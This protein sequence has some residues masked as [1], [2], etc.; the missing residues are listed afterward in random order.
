MI[1]RNPF[2]NFDLQPAIVDKQLVRRMLVLAQKTSAGTATANSIYTNINQTTDIDGLFG[3]GSHIAT[4]CHAI[5]GIMNWVGT[6]IPFDVIPIDDSGTGDEATSDLVVGGTNASESKTIK[7]TIGT[8]EGVNNAIIPHNTYSIAITSTED[9]TAVADKIRAAIAADADALVVGSG[10]AGTVT[11]TAKNK[12]T[13]GNNILIEVDGSVGG[14]TFTLNAFAGGANDPSVTTAL[15]NIENEEYDIICPYPF[16]SDVK[17]HLEVKFNAT[18]KVLA[19]ESFS[20]TTDT[21]SNFVIAGTGIHV[22]N[23]SK[24]SVILSNKIKSTTTKKGGALGVFDLTAIADFATKRALR[25]I[26][27]AVISKF[28]QPG[29]TRGRIGNSAIPYFNM[30]F[31][32]F[33]I[34]EPGENFSDDEIE[35]IENLGGSTWDMESDRSSVLSGSI[36]TEIY[37]STNIT[38]ESKT[39]HWLNNIDT[40]TIS[41]ARFQRNAKERFS[42][43]VLIESTIPAIANTIDGNPYVNKQVYNSF[44]KGEWQDQVDLGLLQGGND[45][46]RSFVESINTIIDTVNNSITGSFSTRIPGQLRKIDNTINL[47][48]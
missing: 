48:L 6:T 29:N 8:K 25:L 44:L 3:A 26:D 13:L 39:Y 24:T 27:G 37:D 4:A 1:G 21:Y 18:N 9:P 22:I 36:S 30:L 5:N 11:L 43:S 47:Q 19:G 32:E 10:I 12:G 40:A 45:N 42:Q 35:Q 41:R 17:S 38:D 28:M 34:M 23:K 31:P 16:V 2:V 15:S 14:L 46:E 20:Q 33:P 7:I